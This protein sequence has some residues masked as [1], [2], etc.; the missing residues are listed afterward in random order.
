MLALLCFKWGDMGEIKEKTKERISALSIL[1]KVKRYRKIYKELY[2]N[3]VRLKNEEYK[4]FVKRINSGDEKARTEL[5]N[6]SLYNIFDQLAH[7]YA[8]NEI[9]I[10]FEENLS[11]AFD[12]A[13]SYVINTKKFDRCVSYYDNTLRWVIA[14][15]LIT[16]NNAYIKHNADLSHDEIDREVDSIVADQDSPFEDVSKDILHDVLIEEIAKVGGSTSTD[17]NKMTTHS[18]I[19]YDYYGFGDKELANSYEKTGGKYGITGEAVRQLVRKYT[20][21]LRHPSRVGKH[22]D[23][24]Y[25]S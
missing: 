23:F 20:R 12:I 11:M 10:P 19:L 8:T 21:W 14:N 2:P 15:R 22:M 3:I 24:Y 17:Y 4:A 7:I 1:E 9:K 25:D 6:A 5:L 13:H 18:K 16:K